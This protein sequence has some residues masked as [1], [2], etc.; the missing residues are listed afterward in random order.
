MI[1]N[2]RHH[3]HNK[4]DNQTKIWWNRLNPRTNNP[5]LKYTYKSGVCVIDKRVHTCEDFR[6]GLSDKNQKNHILT[7]NEHRSDDIADE[8][9]HEIIYYT[10]DDD[11]ERGGMELIR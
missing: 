5:H 1:D 4:L 7:L 3:T 6:H 11:K 8:N 10:L 2:T 9:V